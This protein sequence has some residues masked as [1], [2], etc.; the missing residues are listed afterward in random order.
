MEFVHAPES[1]P[2]SFVSI[3]NP[4]VT[5]RPQVKADVPDVEKPT[6][7]TVAELKQKYQD[8]PPELVPG[9][10]T[11]I[12]S[13]IQGKAG[14][15][16]TIIALE[17]VAAYTTSTPFLGKFAC[18]PEPDRPKVGYFDQD[19]FSHKVLIDRMEAFGVDES[20]VV[21]PKETL[22]L[23]DPASY[24][25][26]AHLI[27]EQKIGLTILDSI[28]GFHKLKDR[29]LDQLRDGFKTLIEAGTAVVILSHITKSGNADDS[30]A[31]EGSG[32][33]AACDFV[34]G[35]SELDYGEFR[36]KPVKVRNSKNNPETVIVSFGGESRPAHKPNISL[37]NKILQFIADAG[38]TGTNLGAIRDL[39][40]KDR[41]KGVLTNLEGLYYCDGKRGP[42]NHI[43]DLKFKPDLSCDLDNASDCNEG[44]YMEAGA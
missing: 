20:K 19:N 10:F 29:R 18:N 11:R 34:W 41:V 9:F 15:G 39:A 35:M 36:I 25:R 42:G 1:A 24:N 13:M 17:L 43:W 21:I 22:L 12:L 27:R 30:N 8:A 44:L 31:A 3:D 26:A 37:E 40:G 23:D 33:P 7:W 32:L 16:K 6:F 38:K 14:S 28:H 2:N 4:V 5:Y